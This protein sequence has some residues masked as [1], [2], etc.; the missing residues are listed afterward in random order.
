MPT[1]AAAV[2][3]LVKGPKPLRRCGTDGIAAIRIIELLPLRCDAPNRVTRG[4]A[5]LPL[6]ELQLFAVARN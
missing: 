3:P 6:T 5:R 1:M 2:M 4:I